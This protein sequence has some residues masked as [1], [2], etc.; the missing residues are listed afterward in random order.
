M[1]TFL[2]RML[3]LS[4]ATLALGA[5]ACSFGSRPDNFE[6]GLRCLDERDYPRAIEALSRWTHDCPEDEVGWF[7]LGLA[8]QDGGNEDKAIEMYSKALEVAP[9]DARSMVNLATVYESSG[10]TAKAKD[11]L[12][13]AVACEE[14]RAYPVAAMAYHCERF[15]DAAEAEA[16]YLKAVK[17]EPANA[18]ATYRYGAFLLTRERAREALSFLEQSVLS[19]PDDLPALTLAADAAFS[20]REYRLATQYY[21]RAFFRKRQMPRRLRNCGEAYLRLGEFR[22][23]AEYLWLAQDYDPKDSVTPELLKETYRQLLEQAEK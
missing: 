18:L 19:A 11:W 5:A 14:T 16:W 13:R 21:E 8:Y 12:M 6:R 15:G 22:R 4:L 9:A 2:T 17:R 23:A 10:Q 1:S 3:P 20:A 7:N